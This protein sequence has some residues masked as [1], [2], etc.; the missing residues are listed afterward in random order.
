MTTT[1][2]PISGNIAGQYSGDT[3][4]TRTIDESQYNTTPIQFSPSTVQ[5]EM[6]HTRQFVANENGDEFFLNNNNQAFATPGYSE[7][8]QARMQTSVQRMIRSAQF[9]N[10]FK[11]VISLQNVDYADFSLKSNKEYYEVDSSTLQDIKS[12]QELKNMGYQA[13]AKPTGDPNKPFELT[14]FGPDGKAITGSQW[15]E[16]FDLYSSLKTR[17]VA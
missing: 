6:H 12:N 2:A 16:F 3:V 1:T 14:V 15:N 9:N 10:Q 11:P 7:I 5:E 8:F 13:F 4:T 17:D